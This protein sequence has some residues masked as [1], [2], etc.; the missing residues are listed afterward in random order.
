MAIAGSAFFVAAAGLH[1]QG[2]HRGGDLRLEGIVGRLGAVG[3]DQLGAV[4]QRGE[5]RQD[6]FGPIGAKLTLFIFTLL[7]L[8]AQGATPPGS[9]GDVCYGSKAVVKK[10]G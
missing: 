10:D 7:P 8:G 6:R 3:D 4:A 5:H 9:S 2:V 1:A